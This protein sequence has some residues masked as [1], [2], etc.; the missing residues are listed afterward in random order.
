MKNTAKHYLYYPKNDIHVKPFLAYGFRP[1]FL[2]LPWYVAIMI[3]LWGISFGFSIDILPFSN[4]IN[5]HIYELLFGVGFGAIGAFLLTAL[6]ELFSGSV[7]I[8]G[9]KLLYIIILWL[10]GRVSFWC[11]DI[12]GIWISF[13][14]NIAFSVLMIA[15]IFKRVV[16]DPLQRHSSIAYMIV[17]ITVI[18]TMFFLSVAK[19]ITFK[20]PNSFLYLSLSLFI[21]LII[22]ALRRIQMEEINGFIE[23]MELS[24]AFI[25]R[26]FRYN[27]SI[28]CILLF[29]FCEFFFQNSILGWL[30]FAVFAA[31]LNIINDYKREY[32]KTI[33]THPYV[34]IFAILLF[35]IS[36]GYLTLG[37][38][39][40]GFDVN[41]INA[42]HILGIGGIG[43]GVIIAMLV[44]TFV[45]TGRKPKCDIWIVLLLL[46]LLLS[47]VLRCLADEFGTAMYAL[48]SLSFALCFIIYFFRFKGYLLNKR[49]DGLLGWGMQGTKLVGVIS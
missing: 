26:P 2:I 3:T 9:K 48:S 15:I 25:T 5:W 6:P 22:L 8:V 47:L 43:G 30:G 44:I 41:L 27:L 39:Y 11:M 45:H 36:F 21:V 33:L 14:F 1:F 17:L 16:L 46:S 32:D 10:L 40:I 19:V 18:Q 34:Q 29:G 13:L 38:Y 31:T 20:N 12:I 28:F 42:R 4:I 35:V 23:E 24:E 7:P 37:L 49:A